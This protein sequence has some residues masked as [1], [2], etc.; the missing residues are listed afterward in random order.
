MFQQGAYDPIEIQAPNGGMNRFISPEVLPSNLCY[1]L[2]NIIPLPVGSCQVRYGS[3]Y[4]YNIFER[5]EL[6]SSCYLIEYFRY[7]GNNVALDLYYSGIPKIDSDA[8]DIQAEA[9]NQ[10]SFTSLVAKTYE[11]N[12]KIKINY[13]YNGIPYSLT[14]IIENVSVNVASVSIVFSGDFF[15]DTDIN[16]ESIYFFEGKILYEWFYKKEPTSVDILNKQTNLSTACTP[17]FCFFQGKILICNGKDIPSQVYSFDEDAPSD[18]L[19]ENMHQ[20]V[21]EVYVNTPVKNAD[22]VIQFRYI[23]GFDNEKYYRGNSIIIEINGE[24]QE[25]VLDFNAQVANP[26]VILTFTEES[27]AIPDI[28]Q[29]ATVYLYY[30][31]YPPAFSYI[32]PAKDRLWALGPGVVSRGYKSEDEAMKVYYSYGINSVNKLFNENN[33]SVP[34]INIADK[35]KVD[36][37]LEAI[38]Q[39][40]GLM[41]FVGRKNSQMWTGYTPGDGG[42]FSWGITLNEGIF[43]GN[44]L[45]ELPNDTFFISPTG[46]KSFSTLNIGNQFS[47]NSFNAV[48][49][50]MLS[51]MENALLSEGTYRSCRSFVYKKGSFLGFKIGNN[52]IL[53][54]LYNTAPYA[55]FMLSGDFRKSINF[56][57]G[58]N[59]LYMAHNQ[60]TYIYADGFDG[61]QKLY[62]DNNGAD[63]IEFSW[64]SGL[65]KVRGSSGKR[66]ANKHYEIIAS[67]SSSFQSNLSNRF[68]LSITS[69][70]PGIYT[71][72]SKCSFSES[73]DAL[74]RP[75]IDEGSAFRLSENQLYTINKQFKFVSASFYCT[76]EGAAMNGPLNFKRLKLFGI[77]ER[78][79]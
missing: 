68:N 77:G 20:F 75:I 7:E 65:L 11:V 64:T 8:T 54:A 25:Y 38:C 30:K 26:N 14:G 43:H 22:R 74:G 61:K 59:G 9:L 44:L 19:I 12:S 36:D 49:P 18:P 24:S 31:D 78:N 55:W 79:G 67:Y 72:T 53:S 39:V 23:L 5:L 15:V 10:I 28:P 4:L 51:F 1:T 6:D 47:A 46:L 56:I 60:A 2:K 13:L 52:D 42:N 37:T 16:V 33:K 17:R 32:Y 58:S 50:L 62:G 66:Y 40:N 69:E 35:H 41:V 48:D 63:V 71:M 27:P 3:R 45:I 29:G 70:S 76:I 34:F 57:E 21:K 73:G